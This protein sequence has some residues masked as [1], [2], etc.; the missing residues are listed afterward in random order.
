MKQEVVSLGLVRLL[1]LSPIFGLLKLKSAERE[2]GCHGLRCISFEGIGTFGLGSG[3]GGGAARKTGTLWTLKSDSSTVSH[4]LQG[5][6]TR[7][8]LAVLL[9]E[10]NAPRVCPK[11][12]Y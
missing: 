4:H 2:S 9:M 1:L 11:S 10:A 5:V 6:L 12:P 3:G 8:P 7:T